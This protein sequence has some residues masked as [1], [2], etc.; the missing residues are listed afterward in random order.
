M[1]REAAHPGRCPCHGTER[2]WKIPAD[3]TIPGFPWDSPAPPSCDSSGQ[4]PLAAAPLPLEL[5]LDWFW[6]GEVVPGSNPAETAGVPGYS[7]FLSH[8]NPHPS[9][10]LPPRAVSPAQHSGSHPSV[11]QTHPS[12]SMIHGCTPGIPPTAPPSPG[13]GQGRAGQGKQNLLP[14]YFI[15]PMVFPPPPPPPIPQFIISGEASPA[16]IP[17]DGSAAPAHS[18]TVPHP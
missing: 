3:Q 14:D 11:T 13:P 8:I 2:S 4:Q 9:Q 17:D 6:D 10:L 12:L 1:P 16:A 15:L 18:C 7:R 5:P